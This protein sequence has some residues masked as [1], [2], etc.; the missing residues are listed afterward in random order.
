[1]KVLLV[2]DEIFTIRMLQNIIPWK[3]MGMELI[4]YAQNGEEAYEKVLK[5]S[6][7]I[8]VSDIRMPGM[9][10]LEFLKRV[11]SYNPAIKS[12]LMS[13]Y[14]DFSYVKEGM[15]L[16]CSD[17]ILKPIDESELEQAL[18][19]VI[20]AIQ[21]EKEQEKVISKSVKQ[22]DALNLYH[23]MRTGQGK[24]KI[25]KSWQSYRIHTFRVFIVQINSATIDEYICSA[26][27]EIGH[28]GYITG[29]LEHSLAECI[30]RY[31][32]FDYEEG[33]W[34]VITEEPQKVSCYEMAQKMI[35][36]IAAEMGIP[37]EVCFS[38]SGSCLEEVPRLYEE[39]RNLNKYRF[40]IGEK[41]ILGYGYN[42]RK[43]ELDEIKNIGILKDMEQAVKNGNQKEAVSI[44]NEV[45]EL[46][47]DRYIGR[48]EEYYELCYQIVLIVRK[49]TTRDMVSEE[50]YR[51]ME[52]IT[53]EQLAALP[54]LKELR[55]KMRELLECVSA[56][57]KRRQ[58]RTYSKPVKE[59]IELIEK[60]YSQNLSLEEI[61]A[62]IAVS[63]N[64]F[65]YLFKRETGMSL[66]NYLTVVR[67]QHAKKLLEE[68]E[69]KSYEIAFQ[70]GYDN[71]SYFSKIFKKYE[72]MT[73]NEYRES[74]K[75]I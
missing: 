38:S 29:V 59:S 71:P 64:Y 26:N 49:Y 12:I 44:L 15:K 8:V 24:N 19:K 5:E 17:Y 54:S 58:D 1:M 16:G 47:A 41:E 60:H 43:E 36:D 69:L 73:P 4:G 67:L 2:D 34:A 74:K 11:H 7:D 31:V 63:K 50:A 22:L 18:R 66:W 10:G 55:T 65:C 70:V 57:A 53:Y 6:P 75:V 51:K 61:C 35:R 33:C 3:E 23:Y 42:C 13:A 68:T 37:L 45:L 28:E 48:W 72:N 20:L 39:V 14:A 40:Y 25:L 52:E 46:S 32:I 62:K 9:D 27:I 56:S 30:S 21:G